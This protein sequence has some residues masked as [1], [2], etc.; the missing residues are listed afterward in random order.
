M[1]TNTC[2]SSVTGAIDLPKIFRR[3]KALYGKAARLAALLVLMAHFAR[4]DLCPRSI[5]AEYRR[6]YLRKK[7]YGLRSSALSCQLWETLMQLE[8]V[9]VEAGVA[10][11]RH[12]APAILSR[13]PAS[14]CSLRLKPVGVA[15]EYVN[16]PLARLQALVA[17]RSIRGLWDWF[18]GRV[19]WLVAGK[20]RANG[21]TEADPVGAVV[22]S[23]VP[24]PPAVEPPPVAERGFSLAFVCSSITHGWQHPPDHFSRRDNVVAMNGVE[25]SDD[26]A[27]LLAL[28]PKFVPIPEPDRLVIR[29]TAAAYELAELSKEKISPSQVWDMLKPGAW[30][31]NLTRAQRAALVA[32]QASDAPVVALPFDRGAGFAVV[33]RPV[34][35]ALMRKA[36]EPF[37]TAGQWRV[38]SERVALDGLKSVARRLRTLFGAA[39]YPEDRVE[40]IPPV[41]LTAKVQS[42]KSP[43]GEVSP[44]DLPVRPIQDMTSAP[45]SRVPR[46]VRVH[47]ERLS[48]LDPS[49]ATEG[50]PGLAEALRGACFPP[51]TVLAKM[52]AHRAFFAMS[53]S[54][55]KGA[56]RRQ[57][58]RLGVRLPEGHSPEQIDTVI[59]CVY[60]ESYAQTTDGSVYQNSGL[61]MGGALSCALCK[62]T[63]VDILHRA[64]ESL[65]SPSLVF[66]PCAYV[67]DA[68]FACPNPVEFIAAARAVSPEVAW[69]EDSFEVLLPG[70]LEPMR[71]LDLSISPSEVEEGVMYDVTI[72]LKWNVPAQSSTYQPRTQKTAVVRSLVDRALRICRDE[73]ALEGVLIHAGAT[74]SLQG[75]KLPD[76]LATARNVHAGY[77]RRLGQVECAPVRVY[78]TADNPLLLPAS[79]PAV[80]EDKWTAIPFMGSDKARWV[81]AKALEAADQER[82]VGWRHGTTLREMLL[83]PVKVAA[84][85]LSARY[86][87]YRYVA[88]DHRGAR[89]P[90]QGP[91][92]RVSQPCPDP[93]EAEETAS[94][95]SSSG[96]SSTD[97]TQDGADLFDF[98]TLPQAAFVR[99]GPSARCPHGIPIPVPR[100]EAR[101]DGEP[102]ASPPM[103]EGGPTTQE[104]GATSTLPSL[105]VPDPQVPQRHHP[106]RPGHA[107]A[108]SVTTSGGALCGIGCVTDRP[109]LWRAKEHEANVD[110]GVGPYAPRAGTRTADA[111]WHFDAPTL[112]ATRVTT[113]CRKAV[114]AVEALF[115]GEAGNACVTQRSCKPSQAMQDAFHDAR[116]EA[117]RLRRA[118]QRC[119]GGPQPAP[120]SATVGVTVRPVIVNRFTRATVRAQYARTRARSETSTPPSPEAR[121]QP[122]ASREGSEGGSQLGPGDRPTGSDE[123]SSSVPRLA[124]RDLFPDSQPRSEEVERLSPYLATQDAAGAGTAPHL[125]ATSREGSGGGRRS[126]PPRDSPRQHVRVAPSTPRRGSQ[127]GGRGRPMGALLTDD[128]DEQMEHTLEPTLVF[129]TPPSTPGRWSSYADD[130]PSRPQSTR[131]RVLRRR[132]RRVRLRRRRR[133]ERAR[134]VVSSPSEQEPRL[135]PR[136]AGPAPMVRETGRQRDAGRG[137]RGA[138]AHHGP[139]PGRHAEHAEREESESTSSG[140]DVATT[141][142]QLGRPPPRRRDSPEPAPAGV[143]GR[144]SLAAV[145]AWR[146]LS[147]RSASSGD[148]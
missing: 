71:I 146:L 137:A 59:D 48:S 80:K 32:L 122:G 1:V 147:G 24:G 100:A 130:V 96:T 121:P 17:V 69:P 14:D 78:P 49:E 125:T 129:S 46:W 103:D 106:R 144:M 33:P 135:P 36:F 72:S 26:V 25:I 81:V 142:P 10:V 44:E 21:L 102:H 31:D 22:A 76:V 61:S 64:N 20:L 93:E 37:V 12:A 73:R 34:I 99:S 110:R 67:D 87:V 66:G 111:L 86:A 63:V 94:S 141:P 43:P 91:S 116:K 139:A 128:P 114:E 50:G 15:W 57:A 70:S 7:Y 8:R 92:T 60:D 41:S 105:A 38:S 126:P 27:S 45:T 97:A 107:R 13:R 132:W 47:L 23:G 74:A 115:I 42:L 11:V 138:P 108:A 89:M 112:L 53:R 62:L 9:Y 16:P 75:L 134:T 82:S 143:L 39:L 2:D 5:P 28:G 148:D 101:A 51:G 84:S 77:L 4:S 95:R 118:L 35:P 68:F 133:A 145:R 79:E 6:P 52:D 88:C 123:A 19:R 83:A 98:T 124:M 119:G 85:R 56:V 109:L 140:F 104:S 54:L 117:A 40:R 18:L 136:A 90:S 58:E 131:P 113:W 3:G 55:V 65:P 29:A 30:R 127:R 120:A